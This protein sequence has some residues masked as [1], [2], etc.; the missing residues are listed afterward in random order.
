MPPYYRVS[1]SIWTEPWAEETRTLALY[2][3]TCQHRSTEGLFRL[4]VPYI[5]V[6]LGWPARRIETHLKKLEEAGFLLRSGDVILIKKA[7]KHQAPV[8][9]NQVKHALS[10]IETVPATVLDKEFL[11]LAERFSQRLAQSLPERFP[12][13]FGKP[14]ALAPALAPTPPPEGGDGGGIDAAAEELSA[15]F[16]GE[17]FETSDIEQ[18]LRRIKTRRALGDPVRDPESWMRQELARMAMKRAQNRAHPD[19][20]VEPVLIDGVP[21]LFVDDGWR[22]VQ[23]EAMSG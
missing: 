7:L 16:V 10:A 13:R 2:L 12:E 18:L 9:P 6:D 21:H 11:A 8:N 4:P 15:L 1:P 5:Q 20:T 3:L 17:G 22:E 14:P 23:D 19:K